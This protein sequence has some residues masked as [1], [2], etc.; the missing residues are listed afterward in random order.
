MNTLDLTTRPPRTPVFARRKWA[1]EQGYR[2]RKTLW[3]FTG[4][5]IAV[6]SE[7]EWRDDAGR[8]GRAHRNDNWSFTPTATLLSATQASTASQSQSERKLRW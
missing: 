5:R 4:N 2:L 7:Y 6:R 3:A 8:W 1:K